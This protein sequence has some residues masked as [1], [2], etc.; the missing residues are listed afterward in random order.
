M[1]EGHSPNA[2]RRA[3]ALS[4]VRD[5]LAE[6]LGQEELRELISP[7]ALEEVEAD[8]QRLSERTTPSNADGRHATLRALGDLNVSEAQ[9]RSL[10]AVSAKRMLERLVP[11]RRAVKMRIGGEERF[12]AAEDA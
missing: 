12:I 1:Y 8:L 5:L 11:E 9:A 2:E 10:E 7:E 3:A 4:L 6:L